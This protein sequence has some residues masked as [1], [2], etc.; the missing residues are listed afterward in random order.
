[1]KCKTKCMNMFPIIY[2]RADRQHVSLLR[3]EEEQNDRKCSSEREKLWAHI[4]YSVDLWH[5]VCLSPR[6]TAVN[7]PQ[8]SCDNIKWKC[9][10]PRC[11]FFL[12]TVN[13]RSNVAAACA[14]DKNDRNFKHRETG[15]QRNE[16]ERRR[17]KERE[18]ILPLCQYNIYANHAFSI[19]VNF[20]THKALIQLWGGNAWSP[21]TNDCQGHL[22]QSAS[23]LT[24][25]SEGVK[26]FASSRPRV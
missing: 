7:K 2:Q 11:C 26:A 5:V 1:M 14:A 19:C 15:G 6:C 17:D 12:L 8:L 23:R 20:I 18:N 3:R 10:T 21:K 4:F 25:K 24:M 9:L 16:R 22:Q 13:N